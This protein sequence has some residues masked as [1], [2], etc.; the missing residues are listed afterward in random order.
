M[1]IYLYIV[2]I[3]ILCFQRCTKYL[4]IN[5]THLQCIYI[6][7]EMTNLFKLNKN[8]NIPRIVMNKTNI[9]R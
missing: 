6:Y 2:Y 4:Q 5:H 1:Y 3:Y 8:A 9:L 7:C